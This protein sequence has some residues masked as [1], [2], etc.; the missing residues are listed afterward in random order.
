MDANLYSMMRTWLDDGTETQR[1]HARHRLAMPDAIEFE[2]TGEATTVQYPSFGSMVV[3]AVATAANFATSGFALADDAEVSRRLA[4]CGGCE[5]FDADQQ[6]CRSC[7]CFMN[8]KAKIA[9]AV[10]PINKW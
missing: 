3:N 1:A 2:R 5:A 7:G 6:R 8:G 4:I 10:C 9:A